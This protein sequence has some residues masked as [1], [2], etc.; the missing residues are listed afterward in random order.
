[1]MGDS[2]PAKAIGFELDG[3]L[4]VDADSLSVVPPPDNLRRHFLPWE[5]PLLEQAVAWL[6]AG[7][8]GEGP[9]DLGKLLVVVPTRQSGRRLREA[10]AEHAGTR[11]QAVF[12]PRVMTPE[13]FLTG[14]E[15][16]AV[17]TRLE[18]LLAW[19]EVVSAIALDD[20]REVFPVDPA[21]RNFAWARRLAQQL[22]RLQAALAE[23]GLKIADVTERAGADFPEADRW[24]QLG[25]LERRHAAK[26]S[27][28]GLL[29]A[30]AARIA[31]A[32]RPALPAGIRCV[33]VL[34]TPDPLPL[35]VKAWARLAEACPV[36]VLIFAPESEGARFDAWGRVVEAEWA[37]REM[38]LPDFARR[39][40][41]CADPA[42]QAERLATVARQYEQPDGRLA[43]GVADAEVLPLVEGELGRAGLKAFNPEGR[44]RR[45]E[46]FYHLLA[47]LARVVREATW[48][49]VAALAR[50]PD[51]LAWLRARRGDE[52]GAVKFLRGLD[53]LREDRLPADL[54]AAIALGLDKVPELADLGE[55]R[56]RLSRGT[57]PDN[58]SAVLG[59]LFGARRLDLARD[60]DARLEESAASWAEVLRGCAKAKGW[61]PQVADAEWWELALGLYGDETRTDDKPV[62]ALELQG[63]LELLFEDA[64]HLAVAGLNDGFVPEAVA[65]DAF[66]PESLRARLGLKTNAARFA[67]D[68]YLF[69]AMAACRPRL[70][71]F[72]GKTSAAGEPLRPSRLLLQCAD[73]ELP[74]RVAEL[75]RE[76]ESGRHG[77][78]WTRAWR[79]APARGE[80]IASVAVTALRAWLDCPFRF[81]LRHGRK[82]VAVEPE[83]S[84]MDARD[85]GT[86]MHSALE[87]MARD[88]ALRDC[89]DAA[90]L[91][92]FLQTALER[93]VRTKFGAELTLPLLIQRESAR[94]RLAKAA[95]LEATERAA[96]WRTEAV[97]REFSLEISGLTVRGKIDRI[98]RQVATGAV[99]VLD[100]KTSDSPVSPAEAHLRGLR[101]DEAPRDWAKVVG[102]EK[103]RVWTDLQLP[104]Y[105]RVLAADFGGSVTCG[106][107]NLPKAVGDSGIVLWDGFSAE[108]RESAWRCAQG[109]SAAIRA[110]E[111]WPPR[112]L[113]GREA[114]RDDY[115]A[116]FHHGA[117]ASVAWQEAAR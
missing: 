49:T 60:E 21:E 108:L 28:L 72:F 62:G 16:A 34:A 112:E 97:E 11:G 13:I 12:P 67:R 88:P 96:G 40:H 111:F 89:T 52:F 20:F 9:L 76:P 43:I 56:S 64:P 17:A 84:E 51:V 4:R 54:D 8:I 75:F 38:V 87:A 101:R 14:S 70:D 79:L 113:T 5:R 71:V 81:Y 33:V 92:E 57:F 37:R 82:M 6:A 10:L 99:R 100:Y 23:A 73:A 44:V 66:L 91:R 104:L 19:A 41:L 106:Y 86:L 58:A 80:P 98:D 74:R 59:E 103:A 115:A 7:W 117:A 61:F 15:T 39:V 1:M 109:V 35:A 95:E 55:L 27:D 29:D 45:A 68:A 94:Q 93:R 46:P 85:F 18:G 2:A 77:Y 24:R 47:A 32:Q 50:C 110:G 105:E 78:P 90:V 25:E 63:W 26:L 107:F 83:K 36:D 65:G 42:T 30:S 102:D 3:S 69:Q 48:E 31:A 53:R 114:E 116:L 22:A